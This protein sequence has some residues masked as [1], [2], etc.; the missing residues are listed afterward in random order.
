MRIALGALAIALLGSLAVNAWLSSRVFEQYV[1]AWEVRLDPVGLAGY[2][3]AAEATRPD[4]RGRRVVFFGDSRALA[5][6]GAAQLSGFEVVNRGIGRETSAQALE[7]FERHVAPLQPEAVVIQV[8]VNDLKLVSLRPERASEIIEACVTNIGAIVARARALG[9]R[10]VLTTIF[11]VGEPPLYLR[12]VASDATRKA[13]DSV[14]ERLRALAG[15][16]VVVLDAALLLSD[17][18]GGIAAAYRHD[19]LHI[20]PAGYVAMNADLARSLE[21]SNESRPSVEKLP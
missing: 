9:A 18:Q 16:G 5:W 14:N 21:S 4:P 10:V 17:A 2:P 6:T 1:A 12:P 8:G 3:I 15:P 13:I 20:A 11:P 19:W 7:R